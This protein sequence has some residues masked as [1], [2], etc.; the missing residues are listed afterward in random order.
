M[1]CRNY[2]T[3]VKCISDKGVLFGIKAEEFNIRLKRDDKAWK[4]LT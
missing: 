4:I 3:T 1:I 2:T